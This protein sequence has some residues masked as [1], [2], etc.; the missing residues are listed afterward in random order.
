MMH[1]IKQGSTHKIKLPN[2]II[3]QNLFKAVLHFKKKA[4]IN[5]L[6][7]YHKIYINV[8]FKAN[9]VVKSQT[10]LILGTTCCN[11]DVW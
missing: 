6:K 5:F 1:K 11:N 8:K 4:Y 2:K 9:I 7:F 3:Q 10:Q